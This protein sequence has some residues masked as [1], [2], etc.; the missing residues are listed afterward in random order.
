M[1]QFYLRAG[2]A[3]ASPRG[4]GNRARENLLRAQAPVFTA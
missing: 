2:S 3:I 1:A 4:D